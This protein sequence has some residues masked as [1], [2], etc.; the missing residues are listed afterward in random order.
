MVRVS[1][2]RTVVRFHLRRS[3]T[4]AI[5][6]TPLCPFLSE[7]TLEAVG[8]NSCISSRLGCLEY[9]YLRLETT[10]GK[11]SVSKVCKIRMSHMQ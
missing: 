1:I 2:E 6:F 9:N 5:S 3:E 7:E 10:T 11:H 8:P 4:W